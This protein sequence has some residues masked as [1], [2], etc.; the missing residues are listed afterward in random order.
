M[1]YLQITQKI[2]DDNINSSYNYR[3]GWTY[4]SKKTKKVIYTSS[5]I[6]YKQKD[7]CHYMSTSDV[8]NIYK[9]MS[10]HWNNYR[11]EINNLLGDI[12]PYYNYRLDLYNIELQD[13][14][15]EYDILHKDINTNDIDNTIE[16][17]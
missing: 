11:D 12:S 4:Y 6:E 16:Y 13:K 17:F 10:Q 9:K 8:I 5:N 15:I 14:L 1:S 2:V 7:T 3:P